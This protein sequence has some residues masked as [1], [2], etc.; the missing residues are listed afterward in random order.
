[1]E[2]LLTEAAEGAREGVMLVHAHY[3]RMA[4]CIDRQHPRR[5]DSST[6]SEQAALFQMVSV[7]ESFTVA[8]AQRTQGYAREQGGTVVANLLKQVRF[9]E[10][11]GWEAVRTF[12]KSLGVPITDLST[13]QRMLGYIEARNSVA[14]GQGSL[15]ARQLAN[16]KS[17]TSNLRAANILLRNDQ[18]VL[19]A[20]VVG[21]CRD[22]ICEYINQLDTASH[23][24]KL[25]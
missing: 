22:C 20:Q 15:T 13:H 7:A 18:L 14:H 5:P 10:T 2:Q 23:P 12:L 1:M 16:H 6:P 3:Q 25:P 17:A 24:Y 21:E 19:S 9:R 11:D 4:E 8:V